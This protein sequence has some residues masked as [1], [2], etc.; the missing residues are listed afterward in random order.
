MKKILLFTS[1]LISCVVVRAQWNGDPAVNNKIADNTML[2]AGKSGLVSI[3]DGNDNMIIA[4]VGASISGGTGND[5]YIQKINKDG[6][7]AWGAIEIVVCNAVGSQSA[8]NMISDGVGG[9]ILAWTDQRL[10]SGNAE[11]VYGQR[12]LANGSIGWTTNGVNLSKDGDDAIVYKRNAF[13]RKVSSTEF[14]VVFG[15]AG[16]LADLFAQKCLISTGAIQWATDVSLHG[17]QAGNQSN[18]SLLEDGLGG[19]FI[20]WQDLR[21]TGADIYGQRI[22]SSGTVLWD[23]AGKVI[24]NAAF[25]QNSPTVIS[26]NNNGLLVT[27]SD[28]RD[29]STNDD[30]YIQRLDVNGDKNTG[31]NWAVNGNR[32]CGAANQQTNQLIIDALDGTFAVVWSDRRVSVDRDIWAQKVNLDGT[33]AWAVDGLPVAVVAGSNQGNGAEMRIIASGSGT[34]L[35]TW[36]D[37]RA[38]SGNY[39]IYAQKLN[40]DGSPAFAVNGVLISSALTNQSLPQM[41]ADGANG[42]IIS[43]RDSRTLANGEIYASRLLSN[44]TLPVTYASFTASKNTLNEVSLVWN[45]ASEINTDEYLIERK[46]ETGD[47]V[48]IGLVKAQ[49]LSSYNFTDR[50]PLLRNNYYRIKAKDF[51]G[52]LSYSDIRIINIDALSANAIRIYPNPTSDR[53]N[54]SITNAGTYQ[55]KLIDQAGKVVFNNIQELNLGVNDLGVSLS[56]FSSGV[57]Y[58]TLTSDFQYINKKIIKI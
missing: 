43:W 56:S 9:A 42:A 35:I 16:T 22:N 18:P 39:D 7:L 19:A 32:V 13:L 17:A 55:I 52:T 48:T 47:F 57:Y 50:N 27:W 6:T 8:I 33:M 37:E 30:I 14:I 1:L 11:E 25:A 2:S 44:G 51:D 58:L 4:W 10:G 3:D 29:G 46:G 40:T 53:L 21:V 12:V 28:L 24:C 38:A 34:A 20:V 5:I 45:I 23:A 31:V 41:I 26:D 15:K 54:I 36:A 49:K